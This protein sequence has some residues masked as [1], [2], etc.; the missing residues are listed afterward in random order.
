MIAIQPLKIV[1]SL[2][3]RTSAWIARLHFSELP[4]RLSSFSFAQPDFVHN[5]SI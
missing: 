3:N 5:V 4:D 1:Q 2:Q